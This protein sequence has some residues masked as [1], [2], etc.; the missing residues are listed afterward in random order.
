MTYIYAA[1]N[2]PNACKTSADTSKVIRPIASNENVS[3]QNP[4]TFNVNQMIIFSIIK[5]RIYNR[6]IFKVYLQIN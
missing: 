5:T 3:I 4:F 2:R 6:N 1:K